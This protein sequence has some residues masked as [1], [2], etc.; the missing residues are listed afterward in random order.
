[1]ACFGGWWRKA[2]QSLCLR[3]RSGLRQSGDVG[4]AGLYGI[5]SAALRTGSEAVPLRKACGRREL[6]T[7]PFG[8]S[9][10]VAERAERGNAFQDLAARQG[11]EYGLSCGLGRCDLWLTEEQYA[12]LR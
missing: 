5:R 4:D 1:M 6:R 3:L 8:G 12:R 7:F 10:K 9:G 11:F 2:I